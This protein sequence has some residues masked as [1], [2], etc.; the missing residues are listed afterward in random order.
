MT[1][2]FERIGR[3]S[4]L[5]KV[6]QQLSASGYPSKGFFTVAHAEILRTF[7]QH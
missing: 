4:S 6:F 1:L 3:P 2:Q 7:S 5:G